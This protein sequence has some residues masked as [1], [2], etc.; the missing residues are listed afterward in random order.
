M[1]LEDIIAYH[2]LAIERHG[3]R[4]DFDP[5]SEAR[6]DSV[7]AQQYYAGIKYK[8]I[9]ARG[10]YLIYLINKGHIFVDGN[11][12]TSLLTGMAFLEINGFLLHATN[13]QLESFALWVG[14]SEP[15]DKDWV[16][17]QMTK[18]I[19]ARLKRFKYKKNL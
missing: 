14:A 16:I 4:P 12:R 10:A 13:E 17:S 8:T 9:E 7:L 6:I 1:P 18:W 19:G 15:K 5:N 11:K 2:D 3:G